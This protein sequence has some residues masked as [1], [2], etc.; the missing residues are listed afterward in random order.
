M[1]SGHCKL[2][3]LVHVTKS[4][5]KERKKVKVTQSCL[6]LCN[7]VFY[8][9]HGIL[10]AKILEWV[11]IPFSRG[12]SHPGIKPRWIL[13][14]LRHQGNPSF[15]WIV[16]DGR[17]CFCGNDTVTESKLALLTTQWASKSEMRCGDSSVQFSR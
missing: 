12:S 3:I 1:G 4:E 8:I 14:Q 15:S 9:V 17:L 7:P 5:R 11:T 2:Y 16:I 13:Y 6:T 10:Q